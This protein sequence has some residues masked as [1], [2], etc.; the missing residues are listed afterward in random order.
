MRDHW[1]DH[2]VSLLANVPCGA[3]CR[4]LGGAVVR[5]RPDVV[6]GE[7]WNGDYC[8]RTV[9]A[10]AWPSGGPRYQRQPL[11]LDEPRRISMRVAH[12]EHPRRSRRPQSRVPGTVQLATLRGAT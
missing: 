9:H 5:A 7:P 8:V 10:V 2:E 6:I 3:L 11:T 1:M 4:L 12:G